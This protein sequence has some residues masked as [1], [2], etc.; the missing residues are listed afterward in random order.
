MPAYTPPPPI[1]DVSWDSWDQPLLLSSSVLAD[2]K[3]VSLVNE[4]LL[5]LETWRSQN[6]DPRW[7][8][9]DRLYA[10]AMEKRLW[11]GT[12]VPRASLPVEIAFDQVEGAEAALYQELLAPEDL[13]SIEPTGTTH[14]LEAAQ[15]RDRL[16]Y[17]LD[18]NVNDFG[19]SCRLE[20]GLTLRDLLI[21]G[22][23][24]AWVEWDPKRHQAVV[25][26]LDPR[27]VYVDQACPSPFIDHAR[28]TVVRRTFTIDQID[29][30]RGGDIK[31]P[32]REILVY[33]AHA[34]SASPADQ[35]K[36]ASEAARGV[37]Y[38]SPGDD[39]LP[40]TSANLLDLYVYQGEGRE[41]W[42]LGR[43]KFSVCLYNEKFPYRCSRL[44]SAPC[45]PYPNR[46]YAQSFVDKL[47]PIQKMMSGMLNKY[48][49]EMSLA[50]DPPRVGKRGLTRNS[51][52]YRPGG[53][54]L[55]ENPKDDLILHQPP[56]AT[57]NIWQAMSF[58]EQR[59]QSITGRTSL[60]NDGLPTPSNTSRTLGGVNAQLQGPTTRL[61]RI[62][63]NYETFLI[64]PMCYKILKVEAT[65]ASEEGTLSAYRY[66]QE[67]E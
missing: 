6:C 28:A 31:V 65:H 32:S 42:V 55:T 20:L 38:Q 29:A 10:G 12:Q 25:N 18:H 43:G 36:S 40:L 58:L 33:L 49:D 15:V 51:F 67:D 11:P 26:R 14:P 9:L 54:L 7:N 48:L 21:Y 62:V 19:W 4:T 23:C 60:A 56:G 61:A 1:P 47:E 64:A 17:V 13:F 37:S 34:R 22:N 53:V 39:R 46:F 57:A 44:L 41:I 3:A 27:D 35:T 63:R 5:R 66:E 2:A 24:F 52:G 8:A 16:R 45:Y 50:L 59:A 30:M